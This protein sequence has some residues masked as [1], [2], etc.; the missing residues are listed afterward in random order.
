ML[1]RVRG[2]RATSLSNCTCTQ[3]CP[4]KHD[5]RSKRSETQEYDALSANIYGL[6]GRQFLA[7]RELFPISARLSGHLL[8][9]NPSHDV[10]LGRL[11]RIGRLQTRE[12]VKR[13]RDDTG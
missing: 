4:D 3:R 13:A 6:H 8:T 10:R 1:G 5:E 9:S 7:V 2:V 11:Q 12:Q